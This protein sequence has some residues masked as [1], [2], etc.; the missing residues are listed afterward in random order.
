MSRKGT[1]GPGR[2]VVG[3]G[4]LKSADS[5]FRWGISRFPGSNVRPAEV[6]KT[7]CQLC[8]PVCGEGRG[9]GGVD[10]VWYETS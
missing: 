2:R 10:S 5:G 9:E 7:R 4:V 6:L 8:V 1:R 3:V